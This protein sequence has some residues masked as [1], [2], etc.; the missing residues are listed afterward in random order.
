MCVSN[1]SFASGAIALAGAL[2]RGANVGAVKLYRCHVGD[3]GVVALA[4]AIYLGGSSSPVVELDLGCNSFGST[5]IA[6]IGAAVA[7]GRVRTLSLRNNDLRHTDL[8]DLCVEIKDARLEHVR[9]SSLVTIHM[10]LFLH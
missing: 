8:P 10:S 4:E 6:A 3:E 5:A 7:T 1:G 9:C 2:R